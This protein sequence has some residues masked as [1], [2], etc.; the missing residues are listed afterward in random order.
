MRLHP[1]VM[2]VTTTDISLVLLLGPQLQAIQR[3]G[4]EN[5]MNVIGG[6]DAWLACGLPQPDAVQPHA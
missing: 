6:F 2:H 4:Y 1:R 3:A 5:V